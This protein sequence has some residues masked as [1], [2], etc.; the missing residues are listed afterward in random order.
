M[1]KPYY[2]TRM[3]VLDRSDKPQVMSSANIL[4]LFLSVHGNG[5]MGK[6]WLGLDNKK[7]LLRLGKDCGYS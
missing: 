1:T 5:C 3:S 4:K 7:S 6:D 2:Q